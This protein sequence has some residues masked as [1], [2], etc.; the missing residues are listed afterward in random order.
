MAGW[1]VDIF[2][3]WLIRMIVKDVRTLKS[4][5]WPVVTA[6]VTSTRC[7][8]AGYGCHLADVH[9]DYSWDEKGFSGLHEE[10]FMMLDSGEEYARR[11]P[12]GTKI[13]VRVKP[14]DPEVTVALPD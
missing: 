8:R 13:R 9:F 6:T 14:S 10:P 11:F 2:I 4:T 5:S 3:E 12:E 7:D 1:F